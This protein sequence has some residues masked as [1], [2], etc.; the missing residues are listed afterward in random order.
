MCVPQVATCRMTSHRVYPGGDKPRRSPTRRLMDLK[1]IVL[2]LGPA[3][4]LAVLVGLADAHGY[5]EGLVAAVAGVREGAEC[6]ARLVVVAVGGLAGE[7]GAGLAQ[8][9]GV[10]HPGVL[11]LLVL[12]RP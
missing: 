3:F 5:L 7:V 1:A 12:W 4:R 2:F 8:L 6:R 11:A 10:P 9:G